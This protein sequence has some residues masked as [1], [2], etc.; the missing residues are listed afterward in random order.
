L[1]LALP[2]GAQTAPGFALDRYD[3]SERGSDWFVGESLYLRGHGRFALGVVGDWAHRPLVLYMGGDSIPIVRDQLFAHVGANVVL[4][5][6]LRVG[7]SFPVLFWGA[8]EPAQVG[9]MRYEDSNGTRAGDLRLGADVRVL[10]EYGSA[11]TLAGGVQAHLP[12]GSRDAYASD[13]K[14]RIRPRILAAG[15][16]GPFAY[17]ANVAFTYRALTDKVAGQPFGSEVGFTASAGVRLLDK[18]LLVGPEIFG[19]TVVAEGGAFD[20]LTTPFELIFSAKGQIGR[21]HV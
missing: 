13:G 7:A 21:A 10:G 4:W 16:I 19:S 17:A 14:V 1:F 8:G 20:K 9:A 18:K 3:P 11:F 15:D 6:R 5:N 2:S 12:T